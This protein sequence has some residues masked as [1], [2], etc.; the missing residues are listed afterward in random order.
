VMMMMVAAAAAAAAAVVVAVVEWCCC[1]ASGHGK[2][3]S[4]TFFLSHAVTQVY[5]CESMAYMTTGMIDRG[6]PDCYVEAAI[7]KVAAS[8]ASFDAI[9]ECIQVSLA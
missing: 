7:C 3:H 6:D 9:S 1:V 2:L 8:E 5:A 4:L